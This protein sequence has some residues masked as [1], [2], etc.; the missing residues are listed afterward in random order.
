MLGGLFCTQNMYIFTMCY[1]STS[2]LYSFFYIPIEI[3]R[4]I[5]GARGFEHI[6]TDYITSMMMCVADINSRPEPELPVN[7]NQAFVSVVRTCLNT[8][9]L[10]N[11]NCLCCSAFFIAVLFCWL[12]GA[13][14][15]F[16]SCWL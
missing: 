15:L 12:I 5:D 9:S 4:Q 16:V 11:V 6:L 2:V 7:N 13:S 10:G 14:I 1:V 3:C 8:H